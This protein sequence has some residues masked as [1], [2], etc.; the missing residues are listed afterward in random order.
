MNSHRQIIDLW[1]DRAAFAREVGVK[2]QTARQWY[3]RNSIPP[4]HWCEICHA[5]KKREFE[6]IT[7]DLLAT[8][9]ASERKGAE[10]SAA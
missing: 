1:P 7:T 5:A 2:Y 6:Q 10:V 4:E 8:I 9:K 3:I